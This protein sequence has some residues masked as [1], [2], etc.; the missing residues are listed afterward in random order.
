MKRIL[1]AA[2]AALLALPLTACGSGKSAEIEAAI[3]G[4]WILAN[5]EEYWLYEAFTLNEDGTAEYYT[6]DL[7]F[8]CTWSVEDEK[9]VFDSDSE[10]GYIISDLT[11][12][13]ESDT[14]VSSD[15][16]SSG[17]GAVS[18]YFYFVREGSSDLYSGIESAEGATKE[19]LQSIMGDFF[20]YNNYSEDEPDVKSFT[21]SDTALTIDGTDYAWRVNDDS[22]EDYEYVDII[23]EPVNDTAY[24]ISISENES[25]DHEGIVYH[26]ASLCQPTVYKNGYVD[27]DYN[28]YSS[29]LSDAECEVV[30]LT[31]E[32][33]MDYFYLEQKA[34]LDEDWEELNYVYRLTPTDESAVLLEMDDPTFEGEATGYVSVTL[35]Y[36]ADDDTF[37]ATSYHG[38]RTPSYEFDDVN[39]FE[40]TLYAFEFSE[41]ED[42]DESDF[43]VVEAENIDYEYTQDGNTYSQGLSIPTQVSVTSVSGSILYY[44][45]P[46]TSKAEELWN[47]Q[48]EKTEQLTKDV[49]TSEAAYQEDLYADANMMDDD[50]YAV[51]TFARTD[52]ASALNDD[53]VHYVRLHYDPE[54]DEIVKGEFITRLLKSSYDDSTIATIKETSLGSAFA[55]N[56]ADAAIID[57]C[58]TTTYE[59]DDTYLYI[60]G[61]MDDLSFFNLLTLQNAGFYV[62]DSEYSY[63]VEKYNDY[64]YIEV[65]SE[66]L[67]PLA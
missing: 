3:T 21:L 11:Y 39:T 46:D 44:G 28:Y 49:E 35:S 22:L 1:A 14:I 10:L 66:T 15:G 52:D 29:Y 26:A 64:G 45:N 62:F 5:G 61:T 32:N 17:S 4:S 7:T 9:L 36:N 47:E 67:E 55:E 16:I 20:Y 42:V 23:T 18:E 24:Q 31:D 63:T 43:Y 54:K 41:E 57:D 27:S 8:D 53:E 56:T 51:R 33:W 6:D 50:G 65:D 48:G 37:T 2:L 58:F 25:Y 40:E 13:A 19:M 30:E 60:I 12:D 59:E 38:D 34:V